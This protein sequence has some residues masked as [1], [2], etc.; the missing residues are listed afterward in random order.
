MDK[1]WDKSIEFPIYFCNEK[2]DIELPNNFNQIK[3]GCGTFVQN[4]NHIL[5]EIKQDH[6]FYM[7]E[8]FWPISPMNRNLFYDL[9]NEFLEKKFDALQVSGYTPYYD[10]ETSNYEISGRR[11]LKFKPDSKWIFNF[12]SRFWKKEVFRKC[13]IEPEISE[14]DVSSAITVEIACDDVAK[15]L[16]MQ[17]YLHH[18][19]WYPFSGAVYRGKLTEIGEQMQNIVNIDKLVNQKFN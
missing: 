6:I 10:V 9:Y 18:Y 8:D 16:A 7:L 2:K 4:L 17:V 3:T 5:S 15:K 19:I 11:L 12:Q 13:L 14:R 1:H